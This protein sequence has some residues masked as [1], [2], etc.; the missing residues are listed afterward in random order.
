MAGKV[1]ANAAHK[2]RPLCMT[3]TKSVTVVRRKQEGPCAPHQ[4]SKSAERAHSWDLAMLQAASTGRLED[5]RQD[6]LK[7]A[8]VVSLQEDSIKHDAEQPEVEEPMEAAA[9]ALDQQAGPRF[10]TDFFKAVLHKRSIVEVPLLPLEIKGTSGFGD[11]AACQAEA[12]WVRPL[13]A[14][15]SLS[16]VG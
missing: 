7:D 16:R 14:D 1:R 9:A 15:S 5:S 8:K 4:S 13:T 6:T 10:F 12:Q 3:E 2:K 11:L